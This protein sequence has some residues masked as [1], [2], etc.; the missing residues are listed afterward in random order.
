MTGK[1][2][3]PSTKAAIK[4]DI[5]NMINT[6][7]VAANNQLLTT[8][9]VETVG[10]K[11]LTEKATYRKQQGKLNW[12]FLLSAKTYD[13]RDYEIYKSAVATL[14]RLFPNDEYTEREFATNKSG[15]VY[16]SREAL[17]AA[18]KSS[19]VPKP[20]VDTAVAK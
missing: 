17:D 11:P 5:H 16:P 15:D 10:H 9:N 13:P 6:L 18:A 14:K 20:R 7:A 4:A 12:E 3:K 19:L 8:K 2:A 1:N